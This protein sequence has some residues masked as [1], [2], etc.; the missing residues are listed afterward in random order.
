MKPAMLAAGAGSRLGMGEDVP[1]KALLR[2]DGASLLQR[3]LD[4]L[5]HFGLLELT[6]VGHQAVAIEAELGAVGA[7]GR[8]RTCFNPDYRRSSLLCA[9]WRFQG[10]RSRSR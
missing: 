7:H 10:W 4:I 8:V 1:P 2:F 6:L 3:H 9:S 5:A